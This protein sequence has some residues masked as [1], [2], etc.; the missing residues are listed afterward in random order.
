MYEAINRLAYHKLNRDNKAV[1]IQL[2]DIISKRIETENNR[3]LQ[4]VGDLIQSQITNESTT[5]FE[6]IL[7]DFPK[8]ERQRLIGLMPAE[9]LKMTGRVNF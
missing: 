6:E 9:K 5:T 4:K 7:A 2:S 3:V 8:A 1:L